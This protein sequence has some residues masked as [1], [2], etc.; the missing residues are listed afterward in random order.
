MINDFLLSERNGIYK[1]IY[2]TAIE[3]EHF[4]TTQKIV[5]DNL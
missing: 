2:Q 5:K 3:T 4:I 1:S